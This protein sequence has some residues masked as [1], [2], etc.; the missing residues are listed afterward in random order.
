[1]IRNAGISPIPTCSAPISSSLPYA[2]KRQEAAGC[3]FLPAHPGRTRAP[4]RFIPAVSGSMPTLLW[5]PFLSFYGMAD[6]NISSESFDFLQ[7]KAA[8]TAAFF[9]LFSIHSPA[10]SRSGK[11]SAAKIP[12]RRSSPNRP[13][14]NPTSVGPPEQPRSPA[15][16]RNANIAVPPCL[17]TAADL[18]NVP[19][20][21]IPTDIPH[22]AQPKS[23]TAGMGMSA[24]LR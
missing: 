7:K 24:M 16:A 8:Y 23:A 6:R 9:A 10:R 2:T 17:N 3:I 18:L 14:T 19:G 20:H 21:M 1:M 4:V 15:S 12:F 22:S 11:I 5:T 13:D